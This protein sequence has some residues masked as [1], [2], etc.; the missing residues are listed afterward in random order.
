MYFIYLFFQCIPRR[1]PWRGFLLMFVSI[2]F[3][4]NFLCFN[5]IIFYQRKT[6]FKNN[7]LEAKKEKEDRLLAS[8]FLL[9]VE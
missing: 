5:L 7:V 4:F 6:C 3:V 1:I 8:E 2:I 9:Y